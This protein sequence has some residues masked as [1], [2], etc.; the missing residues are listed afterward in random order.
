MEEN[1]KTNSEAV[2]AKE[3]AAAE[4][5]CKLNDEELE[6][7]A[8]GGGHAGTLKAIKERAKKTYR[9]DA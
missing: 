1:K 9:G 8:G 3:N 7:A 6:D 4:N 5:D 2:K